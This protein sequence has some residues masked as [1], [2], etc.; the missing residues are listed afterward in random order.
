MAGR[1][2][3]PEMD[4]Q[5]ADEIVRVLSQSHADDI[6]KRP[7][8]DAQNS[9]VVVFDAVVLPPKLTDRVGIPLWDTYASKKNWAVRVTQSK[10]ASDE[11]RRGFVLRGPVTLADALKPQFEAKIKQTSDAR[12]WRLASGTFFNSIARLKACVFMQGKTLALLRR[13]EYRYV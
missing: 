7:V 1:F 5:T 9:P 8:L 10:S 3:I 6:A 2:P 12:D 4:R 13:R 11:I